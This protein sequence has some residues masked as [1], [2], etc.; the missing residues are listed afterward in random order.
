MAL[1]LLGY[2]LVQGWRY[3]QASSDISSRTLQLLKVD[4]SI[5]LIVLA[6]E[7]ASAEPERA[8]EEGQ[9]SVEELRPLFSARS[10]E[11]LMQVV[12]D[13]AVEA[14]V[15]LTAITP[16]STET[17]VLGDLQFE[18]QP[19]AISLQGE[20][21]DLFRFLNLLQDNVPVAAVSAITIGSLSEFPLAQVQLFFYLS[22]GPIEVDES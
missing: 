6:G 9:R 7:A 4:N 22:P 19:I 2:F 5:K 13:T 18:A 20:T 3:Q 1:L 8:L 12:A 16:K 10:A 17:K 14:D 15:E 21:A 11:N